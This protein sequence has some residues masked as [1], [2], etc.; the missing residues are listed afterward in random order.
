[1]R[2]LTTIITSIFLVCSLMAQQTDTKPDFNFDFEIIENGK[3]KAWQIYGKGDYKAYVDTT[4]VKSGK[5]AAVIEF[6]GKEAEFQAWA[7]NFPAQ[8]QGKTIRLTGYIKTEDVK[9]G[10]AGIWMRIDPQVAFDN[11]A[12]RGIT[13]TTNWTKYEIELNLK[14]NE[15]NNIVV[16][17]ILVGKGKIWIDQLE[18]SIDGIPIEKAK[19][20]EPTAFEKDDEFEHGSRI[21]DI[22]LSMQKIEDLYQ[23]GL[24]WG[25]IKYYHPN[26]A[27]GDI[28]WDFELFRVM[29]N[30]IASSHQIER[31]KILLDWIKSLGEYDVNKKQRTPKK[32]DIKIVPD[33]DWISDSKL[34]P[35]LSMELERI[36]LAKRPSENHFVALAKGV[37][38]P[39][40]KNEAAYP[41]MPYPDAGFRLLALFR[42]WNI[43]Q[44]YFP[45]KNL[46][47]EDWKGV[48][49]EYI[50]RF[51]EAKT[52]LEYKLAILEII[53][54]VNDTHANIWGYEETLETYH[55]V[56]YAPIIVKFIDDKAIVFG[57][58][59]K[60]LAEQTGLKIGDQISMINN[61]EV[62]DIV[63]NRLIHAPASNHP[64]KL[65]II[66]RN[67][68]RTNDST[69]MLTIE[70][71]GERYQQT[72]RAYSFANLNK[73][74]QPQINDSC[75]KFV[76]DDIAY[77][78][79][80]SLKKA[81][82][83]E[84]W[85]HIEHTKGLIIDIRNYPTDF[86]IYALCSYLM[87]KS[88]TF[89]T[90]TNGSI[91]MPG[92]FS[93]SKS[94]KAGKRNKKYYKGKVILLVNESTQSSAEFHAMAYQTHPNATVIGSTTAGA[95]GNIS[96]FYL[97]GKV[98]TAISGIGVYYPDGS[99]T[100]RVGII[101][102]IKVK[103]TIEGIQQ[104]RDELIEKAIEIIEL[105]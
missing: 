102:D 47:E 70:K 89:V 57:Y 2:I 104:N 99:E 69:L 48:L 54:R 59:N 49:K 95:D 88:E 9:G 18:V 30:I 46:I 77:L 42:Y 37:K 14:P 58:H 101:P 100:Q 4:I 83:P 91:A 66:A 52:E 38:N 71:E 3:P 84:L 25:Y 43:I 21:E 40:F 11:M 67:L 23:L 35:S 24:I 7:Y 5:K 34:E 16:G 74:S 17:G 32:K 72:C 8:Y 64:T 19:I 75:F 79:N 41:S 53:A 62:E 13:G 44:Y 45:Y 28:N 76:K 31:D 39:V 15:A 22:Q 81:Y 12:S 85:S 87:P 63:A 90:F 97:P 68:L 27:K 93:F 86:P 10:H 51:V 6:D 36:K 98:S 50:P 56:N 26:V 103:P 61:V 73:Y 82:L 60:E 55:G 78:H 80:G 94:L 1:M 33:L 20:K 65:R 29:P 105:K 92:L 96:K